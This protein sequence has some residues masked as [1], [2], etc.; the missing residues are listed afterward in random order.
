MQ[1]CTLIRINSFFILL[2]RLAG[3]RCGNPEPFAFDARQRKASPAHFYLRPVKIRAQVRKSFP[4]Y[5]RP[6]HHTISETCYHQPAAPCTPSK[7]SFFTHLCVLVFRPFVAAA[8]R[9]CF[10]VERE[11]ESCSRERDPVAAADESRQRLTTTVS[12]SGR[13]GARHFHGERSAGSIAMSFRTKL[14]LVFL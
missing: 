9:V 1:T 14:F 5:A 2:S 3:I 11:D 10:L 4:R 7:I 12:A 6:A 13:A 8:L